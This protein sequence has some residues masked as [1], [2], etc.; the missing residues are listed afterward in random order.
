MKRWIALAV[1]LFMA[2]CLSENAGPTRPTEERPSLATAYGSEVLHPDGNS[3]YGTWWRI[4]PSGECGGSACCYQPCP[5]SWDTLDED[6]VDAWNEPRYI[7]AL[8]NGAVH[9]LTFDNS[10]G[11]SNLTV[12][13]IDFDFG[14]LSF[15]PS[16]YPIQ[17][18]NITAYA[19]GSSIGTDTYTC[20]QGSACDSSDVTWT[21]SFSGLSLSQS[22]LNTLELKLEATGVWPGGAFVS[23]YHVEADVSYSY[24][25]AP[26]I[27]NAEIYTQVPCNTAYVRFQVDSAG[28]TGKVKYGAS[29]CT[30]SSVNTTVDGTW[31]YASFDASSLPTK[32][33]WQVEATYQGETASSSCAQVKKNKYGISGCPPPPWWP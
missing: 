29:N 16:Y 17:S 4:V 7:A 25:E 30:S 31:H 8:A 5:D 9:Q 20:Y 18:L 6:L 12:T 23:V 13:D 32:F 10:S 22:D 27:S 2:G 28:T 33:Y 15:D 1:T 24:P 19:N 11:P 14:R 3:T 26:V 21:S